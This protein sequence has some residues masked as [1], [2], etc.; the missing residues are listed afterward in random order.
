MEDYV[1]LWDDYSIK[2]NSKLVDSD[3]DWSKLDTDE[4]EIAALWKLC[5]DVYN[6][7]F[8]QFFCNW[9][10]ECFCYAMRGLK[11]IEDVSLYDLLNDT[12]NNVLDKFKDDS[13][14]TVYWDIPEY[15]TEEDEEILDSTDTKFYEVEGE[16]FARMAY[17]YYC[18]K[19]KKTVIPVC[20]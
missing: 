19:L 9:G 16:L 20:D 8:I 3:G 4:Q 10:Y 7:G 12:Y 1:D 6:G 5:V 11:R 15:L 2:F 17:E 13:R 14:L 18:N